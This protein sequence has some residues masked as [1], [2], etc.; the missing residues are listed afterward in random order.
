MQWDVFDEP[1]V[2]FEAL[3]ALERISIE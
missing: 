2:V 3:S 1:V